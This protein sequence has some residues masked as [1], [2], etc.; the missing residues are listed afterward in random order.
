[1]GGREG[2]NRF[3]EL[4]GGLAS[5]EAKDEAQEFLQLLLVESIHEPKIGV[6]CLIHHLICEPHLVSV[7]CPAQ[8]MLII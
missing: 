6:Q 2:G 7:H 5:E 8:T 1:V 4:G 3:H